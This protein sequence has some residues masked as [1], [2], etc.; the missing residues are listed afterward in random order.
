MMVQQKPKWLTSEHRKE[1]A[2]H[3]EAI[4][5][6][7]FESKFSYSDLAK[8]IGEDNYTMVQ[9]EVPRPG[10]RWG[11]ME[12]VFKIKTALGTEEEL[13]AG[14]WL[15]KLP[16]GKF[17][18]M[19]D[20]MYN[21]MFADNENHDQYIVSWDVGKPVDRETFVET[22]QPNISSEGIGW[23]TAIETHSNIK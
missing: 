2:L 13:H 7:G 22:A 17:I 9:Q 6:E 16:S 12:W 3:V 21:A 8:W 4:L 19:S 18:I 14:Q 20:E 15:V 10:H 1:V 23:E 5:F 11:T